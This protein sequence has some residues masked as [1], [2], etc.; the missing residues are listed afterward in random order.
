[1]SLL[2]PPAWPGGGLSVP[3][4]ATPPRAEARRAPAMDVTQP[5]PVP[6]PAAIDKSVPVPGEIYSG[7]LPLGQQFVPLPPGRWQALAVSNGAAAG[8]AGVGM[9]GGVNVF[10]GLVLGGRIVAAAAVGGS[11]APDPGASGFP[12]P[13]EAQNPAFYYRRVLSAVDHGPLDLWICGTTAPSKWNDPLRQ[14]ALGV[15]RRQAV[16]MPERFDSAVFRFADKKNWMVAEFMFPNPGGETGAVRPWTEVALL[17]DAA[18]LSHI[19]KV[20]RWGKAWHEVTK[21]SFAGDQ[22]AVEEARVPLP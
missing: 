11:I 13:L 10:L 22:R 18:S 9:P 2:Y 5:A 14:A 12:A 17:T 19:E 15:I 21:R 7:R 1:M 4:T 20:R 8:T 3:P 6:V 16:D